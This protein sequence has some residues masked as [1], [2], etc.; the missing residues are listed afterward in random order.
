MLE[1]TEESELTWPAVSKSIISHITLHPPSTQTMASHQDS[2]VISPLYGVILCSGRSKKNEAELEYVSKPWLEKM[3]TL[4]IL[5]TKMFLRSCWAHKPQGV[6]NRGWK[7]AGQH[8]VCHCNNCP[9]GP[10]FPRFHCGQ[11]T[12]RGCVI[13][14]RNPEW[15]WGRSEEARGGG[16]PFSSSAQHKPLR[17]WLTLLIISMK[18][19]HQGNRHWG[20]EV[21]L[22]SLTGRFSPCCQP[23][24][25][26]TYVFIKKREGFFMHDC[27]NTDEQDI[28]KWGWISGVKPPYQCEDLSSM[29]IFENLSLALLKKIKVLF[30]GKIMCL[31]TWESVKENFISLPSL[32]MCHSRLSL[33][34]VNE[35]YTNYLKHEWGVYWLIK[36]NV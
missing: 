34:Q 23:C 3:S 36:T 18:D 9:F 19:K 32:H 22:V 20:Y 11:R 26:W 15:G 25:T 12:G 14:Y 35:N 2:V 10:S 16:G 31:K 17:K 33:L 27:R 30:K 29:I 24:R 28:S 4:Y 1:L 6:E 13:V 7:E 8:G 21:Q 5:I